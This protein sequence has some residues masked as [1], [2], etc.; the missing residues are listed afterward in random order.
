MD[1]EK[2]KIL[3]QQKPY[4]IKIYYLQSLIKR[5]T[6]GIPEM[7]GIRNLLHCYKRF[8]MHTNLHHHS[9]NTFKNTLIDAMKNGI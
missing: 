2:H 3:T 7:A 9:I 6:Q 8:R 1:E 4:P 5:A